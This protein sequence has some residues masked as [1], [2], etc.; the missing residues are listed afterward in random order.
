MNTAINRITIFTVLAL[1]VSFVWF[2][3]KSELHFL[4]DRLS[5]MIVYCFALVPTAGLVYG[6]Y[7]MRQKMEATTTFQ[8]NNIGHSALMITLPIALLTY[9]GVNNSIGLNFF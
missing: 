8:G 3:F 2:G 1:S 7:I 4:F 9:L 6:S 5:P